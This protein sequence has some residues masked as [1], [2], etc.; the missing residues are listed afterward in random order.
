M[1]YEGEGLEIGDRLR[2]MGLRYHQ[3]ERLSFSSELFR[4][5]AQPLSSRDK[6]IL[7]SFLD[8]ASTRTGRNHDTRRT[9]PI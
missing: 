8:S 5:Y 3:I 1:A 9:N 6:G 2:W 7:E 4:E